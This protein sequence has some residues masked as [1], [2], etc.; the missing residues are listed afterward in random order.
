M[1]FQR[2]TIILLFG[3]LL[4][5]GAFY[6]YQTLFIPA[7]EAKEAFAR[8]LFK[9]K[10]EDVQALFVKTQSQ[11]LRFERAS[12]LSTPQ[13]LWLMQILEVAEVKEEKPSPKATPQAT[14][15]PEEIPGETTAETET[16]EETGAEITA[17]TTE[18]TGAETPAE[19]AEETVNETAATENSNSADKITEKST[20]ISQEKVY[21]NEAYVSFLLEQ[22]VRDRSQQTLTATPEQIKEYGLN[23]PV[24]I[25]EVILKNQKIYQMILGKSEFSGNAIY[26]QINP[27]LP[28]TQNQTVLVVSKNFEYAVDRTLED[29]KQPQAILDDNSAEP[30]GSGSEL[31]TENPSENLPSSNENE[32]PIPADPLETETL[33]TTPEPAEPNPEPTEPVNPESLPEENYE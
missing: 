14:A 17:E 33:E 24:A 27:P 11:T 13:N 15:N 28:E 22:L 12:D 29:W 1:K 16:T 25:I 31:N 30:S 20:Q 8:K 18:E 26:A 10:E 3:A 21:A 23:P 2:S 32:N 6:Y 19:T 9:F 5:G 7:Q 4:M